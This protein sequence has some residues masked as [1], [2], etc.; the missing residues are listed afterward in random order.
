[1]LSATCSQKYSFIIPHGWINGLLISCGWISIITEWSLFFFS[2]LEFSLLG[3]EVGETNILNHW[4]SNC[5]FITNLQ[6][7]QCTLCSA[8]FACGK[9]FFS[10]GSRC[11]VPKGHELFHPSYANKHLCVRRNWARLLVFYTLLSLP[12]STLKKPDKWRQ[13]KQVLHINICLSK[14]KI[15]NWLI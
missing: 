1:M 5:L 11:S 9:R 13:V 12:L 4:R 15:T 3:E 10:W 7:E 2:S 14:L 6:Q 8:D